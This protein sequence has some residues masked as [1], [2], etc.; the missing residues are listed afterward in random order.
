[1]TKSDTDSDQGEA[2]SAFLERLIDDA[3]RQDDQPWPRRR[4][5]RSRTNPEAALLAALL[6]AHDDSDSD[7]GTSRNAHNRIVDDAL[8][9]L[10]P[11]D[12]DGHH[13]VPQEKCI[14]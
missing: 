13:C 8:A 12:E 3:L 14:L 9:D 2:G 6:A 5:A 1:M 10:T 4:S 7:D 11:D